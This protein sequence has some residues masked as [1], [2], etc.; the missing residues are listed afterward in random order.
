MLR[1]DSGGVLDSIDLLAVGDSLSLQA[2]KSNNA[3]VVSNGLCSSLL[4]ELLDEVL[5]LPSNLGRQIAE[6]GELAVGLQA[7]DPE[8]VGD[9]NALGHVIRMGDTLKDLEVL[10]SSSTPGGLVGEHAS[11]GPPHHASGSTVVDGAALGV[12]V[13]SLLQELKEADCTASRR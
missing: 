4:L 11:D 3:L 8:G 10:K 5:V 12:S 9:D 1:E 2:T 7:Q 13:G 6:D